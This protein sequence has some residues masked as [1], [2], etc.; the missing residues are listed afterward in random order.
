MRF[1][2]LFVSLLISMS[3]MM[4]AH[5]QQ[6]PADKAAPRPDKTAPR[7]DKTAA[8]RPY[9]ESEFQ[10]GPDDVIEVS[11]YQEKELGGTVPIRPDGKISI[12]LIGEMPASGKTAI[13]L[14]QEITLKYAQFV[15][16]PA[17]TV[18]V[19]EVN[20]PK[21]SVLGEVKTPGV[22][23]IKERS[24]LLDAIAMAGGLTEYAKKDKITIIRVDPAGE[25]QRIKVNLDDYF[26]GRNTDPFY[27]L[28]Y[29]KIYIQ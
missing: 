16:A 15:A 1:R 7:H 13:Q 21:V 19:K 20:S 29:D 27:V 5:A 22:Y 18:V 24:T 9:G 12:P 26:K 2:I 8:P 14:Q 17:V 11:V 28:P 10:L 23:K 6:Q 25:Q 4:K 3:F